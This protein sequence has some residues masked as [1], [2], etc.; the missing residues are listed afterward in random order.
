[1]T[2]VTWPGSKQ[3]SP[4]LETGTATCRPLRQ[5]GQREASSVVWCSGVWCGMMWCGVIRYD[6]RQQ[7]GVV[8]CGVIRYDRRQ[9]CGVV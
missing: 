4:A 3:G 5:W 9:Q 8:W 7:C 1:M 2:C 6:R